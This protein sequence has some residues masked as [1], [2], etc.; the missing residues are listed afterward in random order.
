V[1]FKF[2]YYITCNDVFKDDNGEITEIHCTYDPETKGGWSEDGRKVK[3]TIQW[4]SAEH[5]VDAEVRLYE[6]LF[7]KE[8]PFDTEEG[9][10]FRSNINPD[11]LKV[12][13]NAKVEKSLADAQPGSKYQFER[14]GYFCVDKDSKPGNLVFNRAVSLRDTWAKIEKKLQK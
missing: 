14:L 4:V 3:G 12:I 7:V 9:D 11:S 1:R 13:K 6:H 10:D 2:A 8:N 5:G